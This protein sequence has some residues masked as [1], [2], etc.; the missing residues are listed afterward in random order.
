MML[1]GSSLS[2]SLS[3][4]F[5][6]FGDVQRRA[7]EL[8]DAQSDSDVRHF[9]SVLYEYERVVGSVRKAFSTRVDAWHYMQKGD[10]DLRKARARHE[11]LKREPA[12]GHYYEESLND[13]A[14]AENRALERRSNFELVSKRCK[15]EMSR[16]DKQRV[17][18]VRK[19]VDIW[20]S[21]QLERREELLQEW[22]N[23]A[24]RCLQLDLRDDEQRAK[25]REIQD[26]RRDFAA[27]EQRTASDS[28]LK[29]SLSASTASNQPSSETNDMQP[30]T[31]KAPDSAEVGSQAADTALRK[32]IEEDK[33][34]DVTDCEANKS[35]PS[36][37]TTKTI[38]V[39]LEMPETEVEQTTADYNVSTQPQ[40]D[41]AIEPL[42]EKTTSDA[43][44]APFS[45]SGQD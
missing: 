6:G 39:A 45:G 32:N 14:E 19:G 7:Q 17:E 28:A 34:E 31:A 25:D 5:A 44:Q 30:D 40:S 8:E 36:E 15:E 23:Y 42:G 20:L 33:V 4:C 35:N 12:V 13:L 11:K 29:D 22:I 18:D 43:E 26:Q 10:E 41:A 3:A 27:V 9:G 2:R 21:G 37:G 16:F 24:Q 1:S 38:V